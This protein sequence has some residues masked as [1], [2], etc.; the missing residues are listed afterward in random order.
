MPAPHTPHPHPTPLQTP[1][2]SAHSFSSYQST[3][4]LLWFE[5]EGPAEEK[6]ASGTRLRAYEK[7]KKS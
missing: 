2:V 7:K 5:Y 1:P 4:Q 6:R 3:S